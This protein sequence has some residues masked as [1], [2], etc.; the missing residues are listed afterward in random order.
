MFA[1]AQV[2]L[3]SAAILD[4]LVYWYGQGYLVTAPSISDISLTASGNTITGNVNAAVAVPTDYIV[5]QLTP[6]ATTVAA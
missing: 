6:T 4:R 5:L 1:P 2:S 3:A